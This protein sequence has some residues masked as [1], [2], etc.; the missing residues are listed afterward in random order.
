MLCLLASLILALAPNAYTIQKSELRRAD[1]EKILGAPTHAPGNQAM[2]RT[3]TGDI[4]V[5][6]EYTQQDVVTRL[7]ITGCY[8]T[9]TFKNTID[10]LVPESVRGKLL[11]H[12]NVG[13]IGDCVGGYQDEYEN[14][15]ISYS[16][17]NCM[18]CNHP[19]FVVAWRNAKPDTGAPSNNSVK[20]ERE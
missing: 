3:K 6:V 15:S 20:P 14:V 18:N 16:A 4:F 7:E 5:A 10:S 13:E 9:E 1:V 8:F 2:F 12:K 11:K 19:R 17:T